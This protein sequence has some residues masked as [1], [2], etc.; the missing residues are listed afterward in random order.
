MVCLL[1]I[2]TIQG[3]LLCGATGDLASIASLTP[4]YQR[5]FDSGQ[6]QIYCVPTDDMQ[7]AMDAPFHA[8][9]QK[10]RADAVPLSQ[11]GKCPR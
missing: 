3:V 8:V 5:V 4:G 7:R 6:D 11:L 10:L 1:I 9:V 2:L